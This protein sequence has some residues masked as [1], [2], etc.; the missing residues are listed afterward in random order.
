MT[1]FKINKTKDFTIMSNHHLRDKNLSLKAKG[2]LSFM[3]SLP[4]DWDYSLKGL[5]SICKENKD[6]IRSAL[7]ELKMNNY[8]IIEPIRDKLGKFGYNYL[9]YEMPFKIPLKNI[10]YPN[11]GYPHPESPCSDNS[12]QI[13]TNK[14]IDKI[15]KNINH[16][17]LTLELI[18]MDYISSNDAITLKFDQL[19]DD[20]L[21]DNK[22]Y[23]ELYN[24]IHYIVP[25]VISRNFIDED[26][27]N[28]INK[29]S[30]FKSAIES[31]FEK[32]NNNNKEKIWDC[33]DL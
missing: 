8:L 3:L 17:R 27:K 13:I 7:T 22:T 18:K 4:E 26:G 12:P 21:K 31:N 5:V 15:D 10:N 1:T 24:A 19:F 14:E 25:R 9:I 29:Y 16:N 6:A 33:L 28:I 20:Y 23:Y 30:Y 2:L 11:N 32:L